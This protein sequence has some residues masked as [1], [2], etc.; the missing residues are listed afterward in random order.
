MLIKSFWYVHI[1]SPVE[2]SDRLL[3][4]CASIVIAPKEA[5]ERRTQLL[6]SHSL[7]CSAKWVLNSSYKKSTF[8]DSHP[9]QL[10]RTFVCIIKNA[11]RSWTK[12]LHLL[13]HCSQTVEDQFLAKKLHFKKM[14]MPL[15]VGVLNIKKF[16]GILLS[17][18]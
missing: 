17:W 2:F 16:S 3:S 4:V 11:L 13:F 8:S 12:V 1:T 14:F 6:Y 18:S 15:K 5:E 10:S 7:W 9:V